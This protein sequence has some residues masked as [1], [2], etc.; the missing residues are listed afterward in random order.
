MQTTKRGRPSSASLSVVPL[1][2]ARR[3]GPQP[4]AHL[5]QREKALFRQVVAENEPGH[6]APTDALL[7]A[8]L[9]QS[10][11]MVRALS[12]DLTKSRDPR[13]VQSWERA[14]R[15]QAMLCTKLR[16]TAQSR[17]D[18]RHAARMA[19]RHHT[20]IQGAAAAWGIDLDA[21]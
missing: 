19:A 12:K 5:T 20:G 9:C 4:P 2:T 3:P 17:L 21:D 13:S 7:L 1:P 16:L 15:S 10:T 8:S 14:V 11:E 18:K 6:F